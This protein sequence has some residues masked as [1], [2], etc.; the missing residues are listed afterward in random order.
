MSTE[1]RDRALW[2]LYEAE[3]RSLEQP[4]TS[5][6]SGKALRLVD[7]VTTNLEEVDA[8]IARLSTRWEPERMPVVDRAVLR[9]AVYELLHTDTPTNVVLSEA[10]RLASSYS[11]ERSAPFVNGLLSAAA[12]ERTT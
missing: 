8:T 7:G 12:G 9:L 3:R 10:A 1:P 5:E 4:D 6:L 2:A 11:T